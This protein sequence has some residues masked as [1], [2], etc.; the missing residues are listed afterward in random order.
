MASLFL[1]YSMIMKKI[2]LMD[3]EELMQYCI[4]NDIVT[5][6]DTKE[7]AYRVAIGTLFF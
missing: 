2:D 6:D 3:A 4:E 1:F 7:T 5:Y